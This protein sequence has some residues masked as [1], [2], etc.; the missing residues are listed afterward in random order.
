[1]SSRSITSARSP[2]TRDIEVYLLWAATGALGIVAVATLLSIGIFVVP[3]ALLAL[4]GATVLTV[5]PVVR[6]RC[7]AGIAVGPA[8]AIGW[9][10]SWST[11]ATSDPGDHCYRQDGGIT[12]ESLG[13]VSASGTVTDTTPHHPGE[14]PT[15]FQWAHTWPFITVGATIL[16]V[17]IVVFAVLERRERRSRSA[18]L[19]WS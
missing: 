10:G 3:F 19:T 11:Y 18:S 15:G 4:V 2:W 5:L 9:L 8:I 16:L 6:P 13:E 14:L 7:L 12:C 17:S 1:M